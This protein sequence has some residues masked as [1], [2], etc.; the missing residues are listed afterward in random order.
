MN[1]FSLFHTPIFIL[2]HIPVD[3]LTQFSSSL[4]DFWRE[5]MVPLWLRW[6]DD[7]C[8]VTQ[9][10]DAS[11]KLRPSHWIEIRKHS[12]LCVFAPIT[13]LKC[14]YESSVPLWNAATP[15]PPSFESRQASSKLTSPNMLP[16]SRTHLTRSFACAGCLTKRHSSMHHVNERLAPLSALKGLIVSRWLSF[17]RWLL[18]HS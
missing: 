5:L 10:T 7:V 17:Y 14:R 15:P 16:L 3:A 11:P 9:H 13:G 8:L 4:M 6:N 18:S 12:H 2:Q 1:A